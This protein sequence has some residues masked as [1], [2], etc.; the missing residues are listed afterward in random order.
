[1][2]T[3][4]ERGRRGAIGCPRLLQYPRHV[5]GDGVGADKQRIRD[6]LVRLAAGEQLQ[7]LELTRAQ[8]GGVARKPQSIPFAK[9]RST[10]SSSSTPPLITIVSAG[11]SCF[12][13]YT[14]S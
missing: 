1:M 14:R 4:G 5:Y 8:P 2:V 7:D 12:R 3:H 6:V 11:K 10:L 13:R 9:C